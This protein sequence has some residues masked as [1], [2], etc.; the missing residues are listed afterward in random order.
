VSDG[1]EVR[2]AGGLFQRLA[3]KTGTK[4]CLVPADY[5]EIVGAKSVGIRG[6][7]SQSGVDGTLWRV[8]RLK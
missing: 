6:S 5:S 4:T 8:T 3:A 7:K 1:A 2:F